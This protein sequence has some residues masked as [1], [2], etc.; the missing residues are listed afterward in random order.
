MKPHHIIV[1]LTL[2]LLS[3]EVPE[4]LAVAETRT[5]FEGQSIILTLPSEQIEP[6]SRV[7]W[8]YSQP[9]KN[10]LLS[11]VQFFKDGDHKTTIFNNRMQIQN[12][13]SLSIQ[14]LRQG[15]SGDYTCSVVSTGRTIQTY[16]VTLN[17]QVDRESHPTV[18]V[19]SDSQNMTATNTSSSTPDVPVGGATG[20]ALW[21]IITAGGCSA[22]FLTS[23][24]AVVAF[25]WRKRQ[26][27]S[28]D[29]PVYSNTAY[30]RHRHRH[31]RDAC[32]S[33]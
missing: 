16:I 24:L 4:V 31:A 14:V 11:I 32:Q 9:G 6:Q 33:C 5:A 20:V 19:I 7:E 22:V 25:Q 2:Q 12:N 27:Y 26:R 15:D 21:I 18:S 30:I 1:F 10:K 3:I 8:R 28:T 29:E 23:V 13:G 17:V